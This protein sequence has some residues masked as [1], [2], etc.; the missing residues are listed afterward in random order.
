M[1][2]SEEEKSAAPPSWMKATVGKLEGD[3]AAKCGEAQRSRIQRG[4]KQVSE[5][6]R[7]ADGDQAAFEEFVQK[8]YAGDQTALD[9]TFDRFQYLLEQAIGHMAEVSREFKHQTDLDAGPVQPSDEVFAGYDPAAHLTDDFF[10]NKC[11]LSS[12]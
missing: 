8:N 10:G 11:A 1:K 12:C 4:L 3:L 9:T 5:F 7:D 6:W 2:S